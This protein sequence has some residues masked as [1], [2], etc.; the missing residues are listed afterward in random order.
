MTI[1]ILH[2]IS[3]NRMGNRG[4]GEI[5]GLNPA[6]IHYLTT[7]IPRGA[8]FSTQVGSGVAWRELHRHYMRDLENAG[9]LDSEDWIGAVRNSMRDVIDILNERF[10][11]A[12]DENL[13]MIAIR[14]ATVIQTHLDLGSIKNDP[15]L[16]SIIT[17]DESDE[18][19][20][21]VS[22]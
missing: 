5:F 18:M 7:N 14:L 15:D 11:S 1:R 10:G 4:I 19:S 12:F 6:T 20:A 16:G 21:P 8:F 13:V 9:M 22:S 17:E 3:P 2:M